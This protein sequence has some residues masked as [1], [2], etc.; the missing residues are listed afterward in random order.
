MTDPTARLMTVAIESTLWQGLADA[1]NRLQDWGLDPVAGLC[2]QL[3]AFPATVI[4]AGPVIHGGGVR[5]C[6]S[7]LR[8]VESTWTVEPRCSEPPAAPAQPANLTA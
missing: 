4:D 5:A 8:L 6:G 1:L 7:L 3:D 2:E